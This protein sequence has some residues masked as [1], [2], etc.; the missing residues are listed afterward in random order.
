MQNAF[1]EYPKLSGSFLLRAWN[2]VF[3]YLFFVWHSARLDFKRGKINKRKKE[4]S[5]SR[6]LWKRELTKDN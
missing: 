5:I 1:L 4:C 3:F 2:G 6:S